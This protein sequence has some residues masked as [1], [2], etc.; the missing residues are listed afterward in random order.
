MLLR[1]KLVY[2][3]EG[4]A[5]CALIFNYFYAHGFLGGGGVSP[6]RC[7]RFRKDL[8]N[9][10]FVLFPCIRSEIISFVDIGVK[11][12]PPPPSGQHVP[13]IS[14]AKNTS[15]RFCLTTS[16]FRKDKPVWT[17]IMSCSGDPRGFT[18]CDCSSFG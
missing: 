3:E 8:N 2:V 18:G 7:S 10:Q 4:D 9:T 14:Q 12:G 13:R 1:S 5:K 6:W 16:K 15:T 11:K 17:L